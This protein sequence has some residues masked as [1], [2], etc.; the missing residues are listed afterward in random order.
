MK[1]TSQRR[2]VTRISKKTERMF[3]FYATVI[4]FVLY[5]CI[6]LFGE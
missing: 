3:F 6:R 4:M 1:D 2:W 5:V